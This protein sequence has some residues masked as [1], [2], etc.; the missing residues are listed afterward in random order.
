MAQNQFDSHIKIVRLYGMKMTLDIDGRKV[1][2]AMAE[3]GVKTKTEV[4][5]LALSELLR[6]KAI[7]RVMASMGKFPNLPTNDQIEAP[8]KKHYDWARRR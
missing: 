7:Q 1:E 3:Y 6:K 8:E 5:D 4:I 2:E